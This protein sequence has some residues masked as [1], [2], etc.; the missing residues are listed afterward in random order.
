MGL[1]PSRAGGP[2]GGRGGAEFEGRRGGG[3]PSA[4]SVRRPSR[5]ARPR[6]RGERTP[7][8]PSSPGVGTGDS[9][10]ALAVA[11]VRMHPPP[12][13]PSDNDSNQQKKKKS[14][15]L[16]SCSGPPAAPARTGPR[17]SRCVGGERTA[18]ASPPLQARAWP[19]LRAGCAGVC[20]DTGCR[21]PRERTRGRPDSL[22]G[23]RRPRPPPALNKINPPSPPSLSLSPSSLAPG[24]RLQGGGHQVPAG[25]EVR[26]RRRPV[27]PRGGT[28]AQCVVWK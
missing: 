15:S 19:G 26:R 8:P 28:Q 1:P 5:L 2:G 3:A 22:I 18:R 23:Q 16:L 27:L 6:P 20:R 11:G 14:N 25:H 4:K 7:F 10:P 13:P 21:R 17:P 12:S 9:P 24:P